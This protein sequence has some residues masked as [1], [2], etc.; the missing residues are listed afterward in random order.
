MKQLFTICA[1][2]F[3]I[4]ASAQPSERPDLKTGSISGR[5]L[6]AKLN[7]PLP[8]VNVIIKNSAGETI[9]G[10][11]TSDNGTFTIDKIPE[12]KVMVNIQYIGFKTESKEITIGKGNYKVNL[13]DISLLEEAE[14]LDEVTVVAEVST[15]QQKVDRKIINIGKDLTTSG[16]T[17]SDIM[18]N[19]PSVSVDQQT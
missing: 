8:Y 2:F 17:A 10:G 7:E 12:G 11:I 4:L 14:G 19:L 16:P 18:N 6:D 3:T 5:V 15:I 9:T 13:G 1:L